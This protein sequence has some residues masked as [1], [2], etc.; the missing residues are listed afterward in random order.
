MPGRRRLALLC[1]P[2]LALCATVLLAATTL[3]VT[4]G[5]DWPLR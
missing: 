1:S 3:A 5:A 4:G 2:V